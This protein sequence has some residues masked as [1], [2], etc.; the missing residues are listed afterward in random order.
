MRSEPADSMPETKCDPDDW[1]TAAETLRL[2]RTEVRSGAGEAIAKRA[3]AGLLRSFASTLRYKNENRGDRMIPAMFWEAYGHAVFADNWAVGDFSTW[4]DDQKI[5]AFGVCFH[6]SD[7]ETMIP[8][9]FKVDEPVDAASPA[10]KAGGRPLSVLWPDW[11]AELAAHVHEHGIPPG[12]GV[13]GQDELIAAVEIALA[14]RGLEA[15]SRATVQG[16]VRKVLERLR[17]AEN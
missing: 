14:K 10:P 8:N 2:V 15:P 5:E 13:A 16:T 12:E 3:R 4:I 1:L 17:K 11:V 6:R 9:A 7:L